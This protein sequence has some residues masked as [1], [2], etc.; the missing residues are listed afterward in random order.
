MPTRA[1]APLQS[2]LPEVEQMYLHLLNSGE[3]NLASH[4]SGVLEDPHLALCSFSNGSILPLTSAT[5]GPGYPAAVRSPGMVLSPPA[6][7]CLQEAVFLSPMTAAP[8]SAPH[9]LPTSACSVTPPGMCLIRGDS[10]LRC[11]GSV[12][13]ITES[14]GA[15]WEP[16]RAS[17]AVA[18]VLL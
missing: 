15:D 18:H 14:A 11:R 2:L 7:L 1:P 12:T 3:E 8:L 5:L 4:S 6:A 16:R 9:P 13:H 10:S 17:C